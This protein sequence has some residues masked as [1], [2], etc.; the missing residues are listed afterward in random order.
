MTSNDDDVAFDALTGRQIG[1]GS[2]VIELFPR[3]KK[4]VPIPADDIDRLTIRC[5]LD[6]C[7]ADDACDRAAAAELAALSARFD[8]SADDI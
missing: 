3:A 7:T 4:P 6:G 2:N 5:E 8:S 1:G